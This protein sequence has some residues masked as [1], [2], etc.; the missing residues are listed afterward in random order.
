MTQKIS[1]KWD[2]RYYKLILLYLERIGG[3]NYPPIRETR[4][5]FRFS[6][7]SGEL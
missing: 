3:S 1:L 4:T 5:P 7:C 6:F 2:I